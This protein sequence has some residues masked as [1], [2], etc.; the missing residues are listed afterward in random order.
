MFCGGKLLLVLFI[1][2]LFYSQVTL[3]NPELLDAS[4]SVVDDLYDGCRKE[5]MEKFIPGLLEQELNKSE[6]LQK[7]W[8]SWNV[9]KTFINCNSTIPGGNEEHTSA[10][11]IYQYGD[12]KLIKELNNEVQTMMVNVTTY[13]KDFHF[14]AI[15]FLLMDSMMLLKPKECRQLYLIRDEGTKIP[16]VNSKVRFASFT[17][18]QSDLDD[19]DLL[20]IVVLKIKTCFYVNLGDQLCVK[21]LGKILISPAEVFTVKEV[22]KKT[23]NDGDEYPEV[24]LSD[25]SLESNHNCVMF[26]RSAAVISTHLFLPLLLALTIFSMCL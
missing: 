20:D 4:S 16:E 18:A 11:S 8:K 21:G 9:R 13:E 26:S 22:N 3:K 14:K 6:E 24:V 2:S 12:A 15:H 7:A 19:A 10:L 1:F 17:V 5:A 25:P 23:N